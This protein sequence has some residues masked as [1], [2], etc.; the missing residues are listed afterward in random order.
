MAAPFPLPPSRHSGNDLSL[1]AAR[2]DVDAA[3]ASLLALVESAHSSLGECEQSLWQGLLRLGA[4]LLAMF[5][6]RHSSS[7]G[8]GKPRSLLT[9]FGP[10]RY[11][12]CYQRRTHATGG[13][14]PADQQLGLWSDAFSPFLLRRSAQ[15]C[16]HV[17][18]ALARQILLHF[19]ADAPSTKVLEQVTLGLGSVAPDWMHQAPVPTDDGEVLIV[20]FDAKAA[21]MATERELRKRRTR[22]RARRR[23]PSA[24]HRGRLVRR[25]RG[26]PPRRKRGDKSKNGKCANVVVMYTLKK[27]GKKLLGPCHKR[28]FATFGPKSAAFA[29]AREQANRRGFFPGSGKTIQVLTDGDEKLAEFVAKVFPEA[30]HTIDIAHVA[31][32]LWRAGTCLYPEGSEPL[33]RWVERQKSR[34][35]AGEVTQVRRTL[36]RLRA[37]VPTSG[38]GTKEKRK[39]FEEAIRYLGKCEVRESYATLRRRD[40]ELGTGAVEGAVRQLVGQRLDL[41][42][43]RWIKERAEAVLQLR[44]IE[45]N[46]EWE[47]FFDE[48]E[49]RRDQTAEKERRG[50]RLQREQPQPLAMQAAA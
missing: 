16:T 48:V 40:L 18:F 13:F 14:F 26:R 43:M 33:R 30:I 32:Y 25:A 17:P 3:F 15:V 42:G 4:A 5:V 22:R 39:R 23:A 45:K 2:R 34:V 37:R 20:Q 19:Y 10:I 41:G 36:K 7:S 21:P 38:P 35:L 47:A 24:R 31:E 9:S 6:R 8:Q 28:V 50:V 29:F 46:G 44:C 1:Q 49:R 27:Q 11:A 12:R